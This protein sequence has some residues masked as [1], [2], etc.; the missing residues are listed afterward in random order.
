[1]QFQ[2]TVCVYNQRPDIDDTC[3]QAHELAPDAFLCY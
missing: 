2:G 1:V 3:G